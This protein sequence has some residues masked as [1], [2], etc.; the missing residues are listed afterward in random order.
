[1]PAK[2][3][4]LTNQELRI[5]VSS[6]DSQANFSSSLARVPQK[7]Q[8]LAAASKKPGVLARPAAA[9][10][11]AKG[12]GRL[13]FPNSMSKTLATTLAGGGAGCRACRKN[14]APANSP[15][16]NGDWLRADIDIRRFFARLRGACLPFSTLCER[17]ERGI[18]RPRNRTF[19]PLE[20]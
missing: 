16:K 10:L 17:P 1:L 13:R 20:F 18:N 5:R 14:S 12:I 8:R 9:R 4:N 2:F 3:T 15:L 19:L 11:K 6:R 7:N